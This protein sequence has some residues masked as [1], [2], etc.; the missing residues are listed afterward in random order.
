MLNMQYYI[1]QDK[2]Q[3]F[4]EFILRWKQGFMVYYNCN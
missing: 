1:H 3:A 4:G 2:F